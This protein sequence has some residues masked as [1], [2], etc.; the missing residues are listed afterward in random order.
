MTHL[1]IANSLAETPKTLSQILS[2][3]DDD[4]AQWKTDENTWCINEV[5]GHLIW[6]DGPAFKDRIKLMCQEDGSTLPIINVSDAAKARQDHTKTLN[7]I[8]AEFEETRAE[9]VAFVK[10]L[11]P[12]SLSNSAH[13]KDKLWLA[14]DFLY[15]WPFHDYGHI[16]QIMNILR[17]K[18]AP[19]MS[20]TMRQ[21]VGF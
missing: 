4:L 13:Y 2:L 10:S 7:T 8:L 21:A 6:A 3:V 5:I 19:Y 11:N 18:L 17:A 9:S 1:D 20:D 12:K 14:S 16:K 15:E